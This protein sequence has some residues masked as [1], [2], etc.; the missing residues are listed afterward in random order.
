MKAWWAPVAV[1][2][3]SMSLA[4]ACSG[5]GGGGGSHGSGSGSLTGTFG[6]SAM[7]VRS[8]IT[9]KLNLGNGNTEQG[10]LLLDASNACATVSSGKQ[11]PNLQFVFL[12]IGD[13]SGSGASTK[14]SAP[15]APGSFPFYSPITGPTGSTLGAFG[16]QKSDATCQTTATATS[17]SG[18]VTITAVT[19][20]DFTGSV[21]ATTTVGD[22]VSAT[23]TAA[24]CPPLGPLLAAPSPPPCA[25]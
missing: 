14:V 13:I 11:P 19:N 21:T 16:Y 7:T 3:A 6:G 24:S 17:T 5:G 20:G 12:Q 10:I 18:S 9:A 15:S 2:V 25:M 23:F 22:S 8:A 1:A 4:A